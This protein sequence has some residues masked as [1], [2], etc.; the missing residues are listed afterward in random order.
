ML[1][2]LISLPLVLTAQA[3]TTT[4]APDAAPSALVTPMPVVQSAPLQT[5]MALK[6]CKDLGVTKTAVFVPNP[7]NGPEIPEGCTLIAQFGSGCLIDC[8]GT[9]EF[10]Y[11]GPN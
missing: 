1:S 11:C 9:R 10:V 5:P 7:P 6:S 4:P 8:G 2:S 3:F